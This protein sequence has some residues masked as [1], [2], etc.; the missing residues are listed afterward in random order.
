MPEVESRRWHGRAFGLELEGDFAAPGLERCGGGSSLARSRSTVLRRVK[1]DEIEAAWCTKGAE[2]LFERRVGEKRFAIHRH[3]ARGFL[4][5]HDHF[6]LFLVSSDGTSIACAPHE[7]AAWRWQR[8][9]VGQLIPLAAVLRG[10]EP[11]HASAVS[12]EGRVLLCLGSSGA[13]KSSV[14]LHLANAGA[15]FVSDDVT[16][17]EARNGLVFAHPGA[18]LASVDA[19]ELEELA[20]GA[21]RRWP[22]VGRADGEARLLVDDLEG[23]A[24]PVAAI[25]LLTR[26]E[27]ARTVSLEPLDSNL[28][29]VLLG[30][31]FNA[32]HRAPARL[33][34]QLG[35]CGRLAESAPIYRVE[36]PAGTAATDVAGAVGDSFEA[37]VAGV[38]VAS[39]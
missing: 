33:A 20:E 14:A 30:A 28:P 5:E 6:G 37:V 17:T 39:G 24:L 13:G 29:V 10:L 16:A 19:A 7:M 12:L 25:Y 38:S 11:L 2:T 1:V 32:Y 26:N 4:V 27:Q 3:V 34:A 18:A 36:I 9:L 15:G 31:T 35:I 23:D 21:V 22:C 8:L